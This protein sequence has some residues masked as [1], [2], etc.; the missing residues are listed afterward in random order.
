MLCSC[1]LRLR[2]GKPDVGSPSVHRALLGL[3]RLYAG[4]AKTLELQ[5]PC[6]GSVFFLPPQGGRRD[7]WAGADRTN[8]PCAF[9]GQGPGSLASLAAS[10]LFARL[11]LLTSHLRLV[12]DLG[13]LDPLER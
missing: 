4:G 11:S 5:R 6:C 7:E 13:Q 8:N 10:V 12:L 1:K 2:Q 3:R 9:N